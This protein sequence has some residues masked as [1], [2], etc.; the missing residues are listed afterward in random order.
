MGKLVRRGGG[1][2]ALAA[3]KDPG[4]G[5]AWTQPAE[6]TA[7]SPAPG[8]AK[9]EALSLASHRVGWTPAAS[10]SSGDLWQLQFLRP[11]PNLWIT[12]GIG[13]KCKRH[14][15]RHENLRRAAKGH[16]TLRNSTK[17]VEELLRS[18]PVLQGKKP[19]P[20]EVEP[21]A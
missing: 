17:S 2:S 20:R 7:L 21:P 5:G 10:A 1:G 9:A 11:G 6:A 3:A 14:A 16:V 4:R 15:C 13:T 8:D 18:C 19:R 12:T